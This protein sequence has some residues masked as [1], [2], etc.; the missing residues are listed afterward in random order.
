MLNRGFKFTPTPPGGN[1][2]KLSE[3]LKE[4]N[5][6]LRLLEYFDGIDYND[7]SPVRNKS[8][9]IPSSERNAALDKFV[10]TVEEF[11]KKNKRNNKLKP[12]LNKLE[13]NA[14]KSLQNDDSIVI[15]EADKGGTTVIMDKTHYKEMVETII[16]DNDNYEKLASDPHKETMRKY[17]NFLK[18]I[19]ILLPKRNYT[20]YQISKYG[21]ANF[22]AFLNYIKVKLYLKNAKAQI[23]VHL[24]WR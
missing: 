1:N 19:K 3:D 23:H 18:N 11:R 7:K 9:F 8:D 20:I 14:I 2:E 24:I 16:N 13:S 17:N 4:F 10:T 22:M 5:R 12:N 6:K 21:R 15:K